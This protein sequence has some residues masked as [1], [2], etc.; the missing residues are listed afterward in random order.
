MLTRTKFLMMERDGGKNTC[1][2][3]FAGSRELK[4][5][6]RN[7]ASSAE[8]ALLVVARQLSTAT[9]LRSIEEVVD[10]AHLVCLVV[11]V[12]GVPRVPGVRGV[13]GVPGVR[14][15]E[16]ARNHLRRLELRLEELV[17]VAQ[18]G[19]CGTSGTARA[20]ARA[21]LEHRPD[22][23]RVP[24]RGGERAWLYAVQNGLVNVVRR[25]AAA[26]PDLPLRCVGQNGACRDAAAA[27]KVMLALLDAQDRV[28]DRETYSRLFYAVD[29]VKVGAAGHWDIVEQIL[30]NPL[31][32]SLR[33]P[34]LLAMAVIHG[35]DGI[36]RLLHGQRRVRLPKS[37]P[38]CTSL[39]S[40]VSVGEEH[41]FDE[42]FVLR[43]M[44]LSSRTH[45][46]EAWLRRKV[47]NFAPAH[48]CNHDL[49]T[50]LRRI[51]GVIGSPQM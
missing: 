41:T 28:R 1:D 16:A 49:D 31:A 3:R 20:V 29:V 45:D 17:D 26:R 12:P 25:I 27:G 2:S 7:M 35:A 8:A 40:S 22:A 38:H 37:W 15:A 32:A 21:L 9:V 24:D 33:S 34:D 11:E 19:T 43:K 6:R 50:L 39:K 10:A 47:H 44:L 42:H 13:P 23:Y 48:S 4:S 5:E 46:A 51:K 30:K 36:V 18:L 14:V